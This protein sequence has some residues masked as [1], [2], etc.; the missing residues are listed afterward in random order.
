MQIKDSSSLMLGFGCASLMRI[1]RKK[2]RQDILSAAYD[3]GIRHFD[4]APMYG[5]GKVEKEVGIFIKKYRDQTKLTTKFGILPNSKINKMVFLQPL[6]RVIINKIPMIKRS[7]SKKL[8][9]KIYVK[10][11]NIELAKISLEHSLRELDTD[12]IDTFLLHEPSIYDSIS[13]ELHPWLEDLQAKKIIKS[14]GVGGEL[15]MIDPVISKYTWLQDKVLQVDSDAIHRQINQLDKY[16][17]QS[18][19][20]FGSISRA[21]DAIFNLLQNDKMLLTKWE[22][23]LNYDFSQKKN[24]APFLVSYAINSNQKGTTL[25]STTKITNLKSIIDNIRENRISTDELKKFLELVA[26]SFPVQSNLL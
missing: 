15:K 14:Y 19:I 13:S 20:T 9:H 10:K 16:P 24:I 23:N 6:A 5:L 21:Q 18:L 25:V 3:F 17:Y 8:S 12:Y 2:E 22:E 1:T 26:Q 7:L 4:V 11:F